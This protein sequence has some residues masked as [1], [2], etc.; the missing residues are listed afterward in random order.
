MS[1][2]RFSNR[3]CL[4][5]MIFKNYEKNVFHYITFN[6]L[7][8]C[9]VCKP[10]SGIWS[11][12]PLLLLGFPCV[13]LTTGLQCMCSSRFV[14]N[15]VTRDLLRKKFSVRGGIELRYPS[16]LYLVVYSNLEVLQ[17]N[18]WKTR[19]EYKELQGSSAAATLT[20]PRER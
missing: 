1:S 8:S 17:K 10:S 20:L 13:I 14:I 4:I 2:L 3:F 12:R 15:I 9:G 11:L 19:V 7:L 5:E 18:R 16:R 6:L